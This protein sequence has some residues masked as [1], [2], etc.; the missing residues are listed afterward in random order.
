MG[1]IEHGFLRRLEPLPVATR[2]VLLAAAAEPIGDVTLLWR[3]VERLGIGPKP[4]APPKP[5]G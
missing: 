5:R 3:A 4:P 1:D 2:Q